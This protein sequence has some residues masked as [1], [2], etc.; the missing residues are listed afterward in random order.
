MQHDANIAN[1]APKEY[2][3][4]RGSLEGLAKNVNLAPAPLAA[5]KSS[6]ELLRFVDF[7]AR[8]EASQTIAASH[9]PRQTPNAPTA[10]AIGAKG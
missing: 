2:S 9:Q 6:P 10:R 8:Y 7:L 4:E 5:A 1:D 3:P